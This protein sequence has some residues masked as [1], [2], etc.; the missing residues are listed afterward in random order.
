[1]IMILSGYM[2]VFKKISAFILSLGVPTAL[3]YAQQDC[4]G[5]ICNPLVG[6]NNVYELLNVILTAFL[7]V[8][9]P[10]LA[11]FIVLVGFQFV[12][13]RGNPAA[14]E[15]AR[16][17]LL[18]TIIGSAIVLGCVVISRLLQGTINQILPGGS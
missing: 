9:V 2:P 7:K 13:A 16:N 15:K 14:I 18:W 3:V 10:V 11:V 12:T 8:A 4:G 1:M 17:N 5:K 6:V